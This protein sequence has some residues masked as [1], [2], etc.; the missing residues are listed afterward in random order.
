[1]ASGDDKTAPPR[2]QDFAW[3]T[4][5]IHEVENRIV[6]P[7][8]Y[9]MPDVPPER[10]RARGSATFTER[11]R[12]DGQTLIVTFRLD[13]GKPRLT[14]AE[15]TA[16]RIAIAELRKEEIHISIP[17]TGIALGHAGSRDRQPGALP[18]HRCRRRV[19]VPRHPGL[20]LQSARPVGRSGRRDREDAG[21]AP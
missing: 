21:A 15:L 18:D 6:V 16:L 3:F 13:T 8:G 20:R 10:S 17:H 19:R 14:P 2:T 12:I 7:T 4:P 1:M 9:T 11:R 5:H